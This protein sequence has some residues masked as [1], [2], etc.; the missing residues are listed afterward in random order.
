MAISLTR[1][2][3]GFRFL[4]L[5]LFLVLWLLLRLRL[6][7]C[8]LRGR[9]EV[10]HTFKRHARWSRKDRRRRRDALTARAGAQR[11]DRGMLRAQPHVISVERAVFVAA[12]EIRSRHDEDVPTVF[13]RV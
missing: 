7:L 11:G 8:F 6:H 10:A 2:L 4:L 3:L 5:L 1:A 9:R 13:A 12:H